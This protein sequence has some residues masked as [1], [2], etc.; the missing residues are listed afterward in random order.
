MK[1]KLVLTAVL[2]LTLTLTAGLLAGCG[3]KKEGKSDDKVIKV[4]ASPAPH[5]EIL[6]AI[7]GEVE[8]EGYKLEIVEFQDYIQPN[9]ALDKGDIDA[10]YFQH[11]PYLDEF[12]KENGTK[13]V[14]AG[15]IHYEPL[16]LYK[17]SKKTVAELSKGDKIAVPNDTTNEARAL[18]LLEANGVLKLKD[19]VGLTA[20]KQDIVENPYDVE[21]VEL[22]AAIIPRS[23]GD[24]ALSVINGNYAISAGLTTSDAITFEASDSEAAK[25]YGNILAVKEGEEKSEK[26]KVLLKALKSAAAKKFIEDKYQGS[27]VALF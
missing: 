14:S 12:N 26:T 22:E 1:R 8:A 13:I 19:G 11:K 25:T 10:N 23:L 17:G 9:N 20:T 3:D 18:L 15:A 7:K 24:T 5:S 16:G 21:I 27:V 2:V 4:G 6:N